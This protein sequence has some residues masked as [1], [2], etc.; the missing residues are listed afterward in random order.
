MHKHMSVYTYL[1]ICIHLHTCA[2]TNTYLYIHAQ[3]YV[4]AVYIHPR[5]Q[6]G[7]HNDWS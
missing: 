5:R 6:T 2:Y 3:T 4:I 1:F 7:K